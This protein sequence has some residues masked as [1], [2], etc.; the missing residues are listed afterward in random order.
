M[1]QLTSREPM[2]PIDEEGGDLVDLEDVLK[3]EQ[4]QDSTEQTKEENGI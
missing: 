2:E 4:R 1:F 3:S